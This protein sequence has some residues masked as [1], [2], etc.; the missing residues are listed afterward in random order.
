MDWSSLTDQSLFVDDHFNNFYA[1]TSS[2]VDSHVPKKK[3][4]KRDLKLR[5]K[6]WLNAEIQKL[7]HYRDKYFQKMKSNPSASN[8]YL[9]HKFRNRVVC[10]QH[11][12]KI[13]Y[14]QNYFEKHKTD[15]KIYLVS[16]L[17]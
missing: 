7:M 14:F 6:P 9:C 12:G 17:S 3:V 5:T 11:R 13:K 10:E 4:T 15:M 16:N 1:K 8:K 2:C